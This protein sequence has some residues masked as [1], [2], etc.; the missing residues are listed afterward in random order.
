MKFEINKSK[1]NGL[2]IGNKMCCAMIDNKPFFPQPK[3]LSKSD[4]EKVW[5]DI[6]REFLT[7][8]HYHYEFIECSV[9]KGNKELNNQIITC[10]YE[11]AWMNTGIT[12]IFTFGLNIEDY[13]AA[14]FNYLNNER[15][16]FYISE[17]HS[18]KLYINEYDLGRPPQITDVKKI[19]PIYL[20]FC[21]VLYISMF[22]GGMDFFEEGG[23]ILGLEFVKEIDDNQTAIENGCTSVK[24]LIYKVNYL[25]NDLKS[26]IYV[27]TSY[28]YQAPSSNPSEIVISY[29]SYY[30]N[31]LVSEKYP[32]RRNW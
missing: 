29:V 21:G 15:S 11:D 7:K 19:D 3:D 23:K 6:N 31:I 12:N 18:N 32:S 26:Q 4:I 27:S 10:P 16:V 5:D 24:L 1:V 30:P 22:I 28:Q 13:I 8:A 14:D 25:Y 9:E 20:F 17:Y 2:M